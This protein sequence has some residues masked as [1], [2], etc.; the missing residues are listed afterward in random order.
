MTEV[1]AVE[2]SRQENQA[3]FKRLVKKAMDQRPRP[4]MPSLLSGG[5][6][7]VYI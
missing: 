5:Y 1:R 3:L 2:R 6:S 7:A 4:A